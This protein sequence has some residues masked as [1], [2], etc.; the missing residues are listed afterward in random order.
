MTS[1]QTDQPGRTGSKRTLVIFAPYPPAKSGIADYVAELMPFHLA[2]FDVTLVIADD[3]P[4]PSDPGLRVL[5][6]SEF[7]KHRAF[8]EGAPKLYHIGNN[9]HHCYMLDFLAEDPGIVVLHDFNLCYLHEMATLKWE[10][11]R[12][13]LSSMQKEYGA[14]GADILN[15]QLKMGYRETFTGYELPLNGDVLERATAVVTHSRQVQYKVAARNPHVPVWYVPHHLSP[16]AGQYRSLSKQVVRAELG[17]PADD[18]IVTAVGFVTRAKQISMTLAALAALRGHAPR[19]RFVMAGERRPDEY[20][21]DTDIEKSGLS[22]LVTCTDYVDEETF[23]KHLVAADIVVNLR[24][25][26][27]GEMSGT[28]IRALGLGVPTIVLDHGPMGELPDTV[29]RKLEWGNDTQQALTESLR[30]LMSN[31]ATR[32]ALGAQAAEFVR[33]EHDIARV[34]QRYSHIVH[35]TPA[36]PGS[37]VPP[38]L[39]LHFP[40]TTA[41]AR[42]LNGRHAAKD[43]IV[44]EGAGRMW[45]TAPATPLGSDGDHRALVIGENGRAIARHLTGVFD[46]DP[47]AITVL[48]CE[49]FLGPHVD[50]PDGGPLPAGRFAFALAVVD[51]CMDESSAAALLKRL[52]AALL[53]GGSVSIE[54]SSPLNGQED[55]PLLGS[56]ELPQ[57]LRDAGF[58]AVRPWSPQDGLI[59]ELAL[60]NIRESVS[61]ETTLV[62]GRKVSDYAVWRY[63]FSV[64]GMPLRAGGRLASTPTA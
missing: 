26:S 37:S 54:T 48:T 36:A 60:G 42:R 5:L 34:A 21:V 2:D 4:I 52:N 8:F 23:F 32:R 47:S 50:G 28:L 38:T 39:K 40:G 17:L 15:W 22:D 53:K 12:R 19:F 56:L 20:D 24:Y 1:I 64:N 51:G 31:A 57:R 62:T 14:L 3:A 16:H 7:R 18:I 35:E 6:A 13:H 41:I 27:G 49:E 25:P 55:Q 44:S 9:P 10:N 11:E 58:G 59:A 61:I 43:A 29:V 30:E 63:A 33:V 45:W 46:W